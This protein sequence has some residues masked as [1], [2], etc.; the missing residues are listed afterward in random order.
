MRVK[1]AYTHLA[2]HKS[3]DTALD[4][5][6]NLDTLDTRVSTKVFFELA[7]ELAFLDVRWQAGGWRLSA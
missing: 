6:N 4:V 2:L 7:C 3:A 5:T 1:S